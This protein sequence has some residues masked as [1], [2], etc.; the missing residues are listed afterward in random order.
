[1]VGTDHLA[2]SRASSSLEEP[3]TQELPNHFKP[4][5]LP[6]LQSLEQFCLVLHSLDIP[7]LS[8]YDVPEVET[9]LAALPLPSQAVLM[10]GVPTHEVDRGEGQPVLAERAVV[11]E[12]GLRGG[13]QLLELAPALLCFLHVLLDCLLVAFDVVLVLLESV[14]YNSI[15]LQEE[16]LDVLVLDILAFRQ[17][18]QNRQWRQIRNLTQLQQYLRNI[19]LPPQLRFHKILQRMYPQIHLIVSML[20]TQINDILILVLGNEEVQQIFTHTQLSTEIDDTVIEVI[21]FEQR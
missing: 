7:F 18:I 12:E 9:A 17:N 13:L 8:F 6:F 11:R 16:V 20:L 4:A 1:M 21:E 10:E 3:F 14:S 15:L 19:M 2:N 5:F